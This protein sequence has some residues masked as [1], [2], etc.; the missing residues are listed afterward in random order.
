MQ[1]PYPDVRFA[2]YIPERSAFHR[3]FCIFIVT[4]AK[5]YAIIT[6]DN[7]DNNFLFI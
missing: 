5:K 2:T 4:K 1:H 6:A 7:A 3:R